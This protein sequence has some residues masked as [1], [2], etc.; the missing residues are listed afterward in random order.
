MQLQPIEAVELIN[1]LA[2]QCGLD[3]ATRPKDDYATWR[4][5]DPNVLPDTEQTGLGAW[6]LSDGARE[7]LQANKAIKEVRVGEPE[8]P[9]L[10]E[11]TN[12]P[13]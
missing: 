7:R 1:T 10:P 2:A 3:V 9:L 12:E 4:S 6:Q 11:E 13:E 5:W 8:K